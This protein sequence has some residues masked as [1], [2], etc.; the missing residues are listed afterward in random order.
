MMMYF[1]DFA[2][3]GA[4]LM[5]GLYF[6][7][8]YA[9]RRGKLSPLYFGI[10]VL[11]NALNLLSKN[12]DIYVN[13]WSDFSNDSLLIFNHF[14]FTLSIAFLGLYFRTIYRKFISE[15]LIDGFITFYFVL[16]VIAFF[17]P[18]AY[19]SSFEW[20]L[21]LSLIVFF[22]LLILYL[23][24]A[25]LDNKKGSIL[26]MIAV[27]I[28]LLAIMNDVL[29]IKGIVKTTELYFVAVFIFVLLQA[30]YISLKN[31]LI[32]NE[33]IMLSN[34][35]DYHHKNLEKIIEEKTQNIEIM[36]AEMNEQK[37][38]LQDLKYQLDERKEDLQAQSEMLDVV[39][40]ALDEERKKSDSLLLNILPEKI[41]NELK[42]KGEAKPML[43]P[44]AS[45]LFTDFVSFSK[46]AA[47]MS[48]EELI[49]ELH[50]YFCHFDDVVDKY[51]VDKIKT[52]GDAYLCVS[53]IMG[54]KGNRVAACVM[55]GL[56]ICRLMLNMMEERKGTNH[57]CFEIRIGIHTGP[58]ISGIVG[59]TKFA[60][61]IWGDTVNT[62]KRI[63][64]AC[65]PGEL[66]ISGSTYERVKD[67]FVCTERGNIRVKHKGNIEMY[68]VKRLK[69]LY[70]ADEDGFIPNEKFYEIIGLC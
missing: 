63:E 21:L 69:P 22:S 68:F 51:K 13:L 40:K 38:F 66:N 32:T 19:H 12:P 49:K 45:V 60:F 67:Y 70:S 20:F 33:N 6:I 46:I 17:I 55:T 3:F 56:E 37:D 64:S 52:I 62:A 4:L 8:F 15:I 1:I 5:A 25:I 18:L 43:F 48:P 53:G 34:E 50:L 42:N 14:S 35:L 59:K 2:V 39:N 31:S 44:E 23:F 10:F 41:A 16:S 26:F 24:K 61:D 54:R 11:L 28:L 9:A 29:F 27:I 58:V 7:A 36:S 57:Y 30:V 65:N 47:N